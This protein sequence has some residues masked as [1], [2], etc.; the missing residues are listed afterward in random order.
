MRS[1]SFAYFLL[2]LK[3]RIVMAPMTRS[4]S[5]GHV[6]GDNVVAYYRRRA[7]GG[8]GLILTEGTPPP[9][10]GSHGYPDVPSFYGEAALEAWKRVVDE[11]HEEGVESS[12]DPVIEVLV[13]VLSARL[14]DQGPGI[15]TL[16]EEGPDRRIEQQSTLTVDLQWEHGAVVPGWGRGT[17]PALRDQRWLTASHWYDGSRFP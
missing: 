5:P 15:V 16:H 13:D 12:L 11:V 4:K 10:L 14:H 1:K 7:E 17:L 3:N 2:H 6:L 8:V 9:H